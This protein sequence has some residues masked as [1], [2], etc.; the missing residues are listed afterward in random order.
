M[1]KFL[2]K[3]FIGSLLLILAVG[4][5]EIVS[6]QIDKQIA[7]IHN[8]Y[9]ETNKKVAECEKNGEY[10]TTFLNEMVVNK[11]TAHIRPSEFS[12]RFTNFITPTET[13]K[14]IR[15]PIIY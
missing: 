14:K 4:A 12:K 15:I 7:E 8:L 3:H 5:A 2:R 9:R 11:N 13:A 1:M 6:G 10:S